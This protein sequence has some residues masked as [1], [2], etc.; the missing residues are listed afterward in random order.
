VGL[1]INPG[2]EGGSLCLDQGC[3][4]ASVPD[5]GGH[6]LRIDARGID[7]GKPGHQDNQDGTPHPGRDAPPPGKP[8]RG[9]PSLA[10]SMATAIPTADIGEPGN[11][12]TMPRIE[13]QA[14]AQA[15]RLQRFMPSRRRR[16]LQYG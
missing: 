5:M 2:R 13:N 8:S 15:R 9:H 14:A 16:D 7:E 4:R 12:T 3:S 1:D 6:K 10:P 11:N